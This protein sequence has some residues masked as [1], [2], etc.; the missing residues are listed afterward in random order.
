MPFVKKFSDE[1]KAD[2]VALVESGMPHK[3]TAAHAGCSDETL[4]G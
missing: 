4:K 1:T 2:A 3:E